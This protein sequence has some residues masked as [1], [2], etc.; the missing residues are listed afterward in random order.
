[1][2]IY[3]GLSV[4]Y[5]YYSIYCILSIQYEYNVFNVCTVNSVWVHVSSVVYIVMWQKKKLFDWT[6]SYN[7]QMNAESR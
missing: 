5:I 2:C 7:M 4:V 3:L 1:M 6:L